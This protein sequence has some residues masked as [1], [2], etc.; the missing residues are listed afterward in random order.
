M[1]SQ[2]SRYCAIPGDA[3]FQCRGVMPSGRLNSLT[4]PRLPLRLPHWY[5]SRLT[6]G[7]LLRAACRRCRV[8]INLLTHHQTPTLRC[9]VQLCLSRG[10][11][12]EHA[13]LPLPDG[14]Q[15]I[16]ARLAPDLV[17]QMPRAQ[18]RRSLESSERANN[19]E[20]YKV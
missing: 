10:R 18:S 17:L 5:P 14:G 19:A 1:S 2:A 8:S 15:A 7:P 3:C 13:K 11:C 20:L 12:P 4:L 6:C 16:A 9:A